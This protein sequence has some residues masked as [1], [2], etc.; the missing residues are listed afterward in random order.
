MGHA[1]QSFSAEEERKKK[2]AAQ[3]ADSS[4]AE[5]LL[6]GCYFVSSKVVARLGLQKKQVHAGHV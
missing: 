1:T 4:A 5:A 6:P 3:E 2:E